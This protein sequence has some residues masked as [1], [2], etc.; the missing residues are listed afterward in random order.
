MLPLSTYSPALP[1]VQSDAS[2]AVVGHILADEI[3]WRS[4]I[5]GL[6][7]EMRDVLLAD[8]RGK[9]YDTEKVTLPALIRE[10][11]SLLELELKVIETTKSLN[12]DS[13]KRGQIADLLAREELMREQLT[14]RGLLG[15]DGKLKALR[16]GPTTTE[17]SDARPPDPSSGE[18]PGG[19]LL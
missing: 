5:L 9:L 19:G 17:E 7:G 6:V 11:R 16:P 4:S 8:I 1:A 2:R 18:Q 10:A 3:A 13:M 14:A 12:P 15:P